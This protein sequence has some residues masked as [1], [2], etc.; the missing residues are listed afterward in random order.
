[1]TAGSFLVYSNVTSVVICEI[2]PLIPSRVASYFSQE[3]YNVVKNPRVRIVYDDARHFLLTTREKFD[4]ITSDPIHPWVKGAATLYTREYFEMAKRH[5][6]P[7]GLVTQWVPLYESNP[8]VVKSEVA[9][10]FAAFPDGTVWSNDDNGEGYDTVL[11]GSAE[12]LTINLD[13]IQE[14]LTR[15]PA[16]RRSLGDVGFGSAITLLSTYAGGGADL[17]PWL[18]HAEI[19][20]DRDLRLQYLAGFA[21][22]LYQEGSIYN[23]MV[24][25]RKYPEKLFTGSEENTGALRDALE[26]PKSGH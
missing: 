9:T 17:A 25:Y 18:K 1:M 22:N 2:E 26:R 21:A 10:F 11:L 12:P 3:N 16:V 4:I 6:K 8:E 7:G 19:N 23:E 13:D 14:R 24:A 20:H 15:E 5:L